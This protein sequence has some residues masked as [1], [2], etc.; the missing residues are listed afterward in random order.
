[1]PP[2]IVVTKKLPA[3][4]NITVGYLLDETGEGNVLKDPDMFK[5]LNDIEKMAPAEKD[6]VLFA[7]DA[8]TQK[9]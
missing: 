1:M 8:M 6:N 5:W 7:L 4:L 9:K 3:N 2:L